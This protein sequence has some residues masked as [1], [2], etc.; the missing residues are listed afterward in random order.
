MRSK[1]F[2]FVGGWIC[3]LPLLAP[4]LSTRALGAGLPS[5]LYEEWRREPAP[6][7]G[8]PV[9]TN[10]PSLQWPSVKHWEGRDVRYEVEL[11]DD[12]QFGKARTVQGQP[13]RACFFNPHK[14][15]APGTWHWRY[16]IQ[17]GAA[18]VTKGPYAFVVN[19]DTPVFE[20]APFDTFAAAVPTR[21]PIV[22]TLGRDITAVRKAAA[23]H[24]LAPAVI[25]AGRKAAVAEVY[26]G[27]IDAA[28]D[29]ARARTLSRQAG[30]ETRL[31]NDLVDACTLVDDAPMRA[32]LVRRLDVLLKWPTDDLL[33]S[34]VL[35]ALT[36]AYDAVGAQLPAD[37]RARI[38][39][40]IDT[41]L[42]TG[43]SAWPG[44][45]EGRQVENHFWQ[46][47]LAANFTAALATLHDLPASREMLEYTYGL[48]LARFPNL[49]TQDGGWAEGLGYFG[50]NRSAV[51]DMALLIK[52]VGHVD[53]FEMPWYRS[54]TDY[55]IY[56]APAGGPI[57]G[58]G[59]MHDRVVGGGDVGGGMML[60]VGHETGDPKALYRA[61]LSGGSAER[62]YRI[63][64]NLP[65]APA[66]VAP[67]T[68]LP[69]A[70]LFAG[71]GLA[72][73]HTDVSDGSRDTAV[74]FRSSPFGA[75]GHM[76]ANQNAFNLSRRGEPLFYS[77][78]YYT[79]FADP[80]SLS[81]YRHT[82]AH[83]AILVNGCGQAFGHEGYGWVKRFA[84]GREIGYVCG[85]A[86]MAYRQ[87]T[88]TQ[89]LGMLA[90]SR[91]A[92]T[93]RNGFGDAKLKLFE[94]HL[95]LVR[96]D[97][98]V[99][100]DV[101]ESEDDSDWA[102]LL[103]AMKPPTLDRDGRLT[104]DTGK[105]VAVATVTGSGALRPVLT[106][107]FHTKPED[108]LRK[109]KATPN[110]F[111][112]SYESAAKS[113][114]MRF[115]TIVQMSDSGART[116]PVVADGDGALRVGPIRVRAELG[117]D[118]P[119]SLSVQT[120]ASSLFVNAWPGSAH[121]TPLPATA[122]PATLLVETRDGKTGV[123]VSENRPPPS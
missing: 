58:F 20:S 84:D 111:H 30:R 122:N 37:T 7:N 8:G 42:R 54:L 93:P 62:W 43:L 114:A 38:L 82:R 18:R 39:S 74:Y 41:R 109:Y 123:T 90:E 53:V 57:D 94:R 88:D 5:V 26:D 3:F 14:K 11:S 77:S 66:G 87:T 121:G 91:I 46:M 16:Q 107:Q 60:V 10:P 80:H 100:Y 97:T 12:P 17:D 63:V 49:A 108:V 99:V 81:S 110:Q 119:A 92:P 113:K 106:D 22:V 44:N 40:A 118:K 23:D 112:V 45:I 86:T 50:V 48:F 25:D 85:D 2:P 78:G 32:A 61:G 19:A 95:A 13:Q 102:L 104:L 89:F 71:V 120:T 36:R 105:S 96:P 76:H 27:P 52:A 6:A 115:L 73:L 9:S 4:P 98:L 64:N 68:G 101:L 24:P 83:N 69:Q 70:R 47:E 67:P 35:T 33:G 56:F 21:R 15:L 117:A 59:D 55:L 51:V 75:K 72:A 65:A 29:P 28:N 79:S 116:A 103:H 1:L 34:Q 31:V